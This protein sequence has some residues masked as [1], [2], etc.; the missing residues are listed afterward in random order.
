[1]VI[2]SLRMFEEDDDAEHWL[3]D[4]VSAELVS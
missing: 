1:V 4:A 3:L 2:V